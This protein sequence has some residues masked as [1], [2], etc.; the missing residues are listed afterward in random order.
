V[1]AGG[2]VD[3]PIVSRA[4]DIQGY[5]AQLVNDLGPG[6]LTVILAALVLITLG[7]RA[8]QRRKQHHEAGT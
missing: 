1:L 3:D 2:D 4:Q 8:L 5:A 7:L 6:G